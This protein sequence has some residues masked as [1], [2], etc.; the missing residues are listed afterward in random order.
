LIISCSGGTSS[1]SGL[2]HPV[3]IAVCNVDVRVVE[4]AVQEAAGGGVLRQ[5]PAPLVE[6]PVAGDVEGAVFVGS[7]DE[8]AQQVGA[9]VI[10]RGE[11]D[12]VDQD[13]VDAEQV[14]DDAAG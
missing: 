10:E 7:G 9:G 13:Q 12:F 14:L 11:P 4:Q 1:S 3:R 5:E 6:W 8:P 2:A